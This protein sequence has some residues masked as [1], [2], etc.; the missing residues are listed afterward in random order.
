MLCLFKKILLLTLA[1]TQLFA[2]L[3]HAHTGNSNNPG[4]HVPGLESFLKAKDAPG[5]E[6][7][8]SSWH[9]DGLL[10]VVDA[11]INKPMV[12]AVATQ[13][14]PQ[15]F[16]FVNPSL[17]IHSLSAYHHNFSPHVNYFSPHQ[18]AAP[19]Q[20]PRAPPLKTAN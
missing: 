18:K 10:V 1:I 14:E 4:I 16:V 11:G 6:N 13:S 2:P 7:V 12:M 20:S 8:K 17:K 15:L 19:P 5:L 3:V 9:S